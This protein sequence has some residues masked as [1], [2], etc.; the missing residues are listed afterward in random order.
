MLL[1][2]NNIPPDSL[3]VGI[4]R[5]ATL[6][7][8][9]LRALQIPEKDWD[10]DLINIDTQFPKWIQDLYVEDS[11]NAPVVDFFK[12]YYRW[13]M[14][15][16]DG[17]GC[18]FYLEKLRDILYVKDDF[19]QAYADDVFSGALDLSTYPELKTTFRKFYLCYARDY[20]KIRGTPE[21]IIY[22]LKSLFGATTATVIT[23]SAT[24]IKITSNV[25]STYHDLIRT[26]VCP[27]GFTVTFE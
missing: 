1:L 20:F 22:A 3:Q 5:I 25:S 27:F 23:T 21:G 14:D 17:Y 8:N 9:N 18:G 13:L 7:Q 24:N 10:G 12:Y 11:S 15:Y 2:L 19:L 4:D 16:D 26:T 6:V